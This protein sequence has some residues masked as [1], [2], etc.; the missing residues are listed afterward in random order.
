M[1]E[2]KRITIP[3]DEDIDTIRDFIERD[4]GIKMSYVQVINFLIHFYM[5]HAQEP[6]TRW[7]SLQSKAET[8]A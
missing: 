6:R 3:V 8:H 1:S 4:T 5:K 7:A 2:T